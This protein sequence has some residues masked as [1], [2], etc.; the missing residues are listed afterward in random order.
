MVLVLAA[1]VLAALLV[2]A[3]VAIQRASGPEATS[4]AAAAQKLPVGA[5]AAIWSILEVVPDP[6]NH[7][8]LTRD[9]TGEV[10]ITGTPLDPEL[11]PASPRPAVTE[12]DAALPDPPAWL[13]E[14][15]APDPAPSAAPEAPFVSAPP[16]PRV[17]L[18]AMAA[19]AV[20]AAGHRPPPFDDAA[21]FD[22]P[23]GFVDADRSVDADPPVA[24]APFD[25]FRTDELPVVDL[26]GEELDLRELERRSMATSEQRH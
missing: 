15:P 19:A 8:A 14:A 3:L 22:D 9:L 21:P 4:D 23:D 2:L 20:A 6:R 17:P 25:L 13:P 24:A 18:P 7:L 16:A 12:P 26:S 5:E 10:R 1:I 11:R